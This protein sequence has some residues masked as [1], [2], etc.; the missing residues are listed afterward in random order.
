MSSDIMEAALDYFAR[1]GLRS[2]CAALADKY[3]RYGDFRGQIAY[4]RMDATAPVRMFVGMD[5]ASWRRRQSLSVSTFIEAYQH[6]R[7]APVPLTTVVEAVTGQPLVKRSEQRADTE[8][9]LQQRVELV[10][11]N[12]PR[13]Y[14]ALGEA[15]VQR[16]LRQDK[17]DQDVFAQLERLLTNL[18][19]E[20]L[21]L[22]VFAY[23][24]TGNP[25][26]LDQKTQL[27]RM[28]EQALGGVF[29][30]PSD[31]SRDVDA[32]YLRAKIVRDDILN[33]VT[34]RNLTADQPL[35]R[36]AV[37]T[38][39]VWNVPLMLLSQLS[40]VRPST[41]NRV[42][43]IENSSVFAVITHALPQVPI[44]MTAGQFS[45]AVWRLL[46]LLPDTTEIFYAGDLDPAGLSMAAK[47]MAAY[48]HRVQ[49][50]G[51][52]VATYRRFTGNTADMTADK[53]RVLAGVNAPELAPVVAEMQW[54]GKVVYQEELLPEL[55]A[56]IEQMGE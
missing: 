54:T 11:E 32:L 12:T 13:S 48:P 41:G 52:D 6:S 19:Q 34:V 56:A 53:R 14:A 44:V 21:R 55:I 20:M 36:A 25:H 7:F 43:L 29:A 33:F 26:A 46:D 49:L 42:V 37:D 22:P 8:A 17:V 23:Q 2:V 18:P 15:R 24:Q 50:F 16:Y 9:K 10:R 51:M 35:F 4:A 27:G 40:L 28:F 47:L 31:S 5:V 45:A 1:P 3:G 30:L 39:V 38:D